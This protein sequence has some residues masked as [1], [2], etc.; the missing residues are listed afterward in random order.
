MEALFSLQDRRS[1]KEEKQPLCRRTRVILVTPWA[2][3]SVD[4]SNNTNDVIALKY[5]FEELVARLTSPESLVLTADSRHLELQPG[6]V[7][8]ICWTQREGLT[9][10]SRP[11]SPTIH[12]SEDHPAATDSGCR[13]SCPWWC[14]R[15]GN[16]HTGRGRPARGC[17]ASRRQVCGVPG[18]RSPSRPAPPP[19]PHPHIR[20][21]S[22]P[23][24]S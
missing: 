23:T 12:L 1:K 7:T 3:Q 17:S 18:S 16:P 10:P 5:G 4:I 8:W 22:P 19:T 2:L 20:T 9:R 24:S 15:A 13:L 6:L 11:P 14:G 21:P